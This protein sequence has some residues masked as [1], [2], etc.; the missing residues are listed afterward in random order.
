MVVS[1]TIAKASWRFEEQ[2]ERQQELHGGF[3]NNRNNSKGFMV[4][5][6]TAIG[7][8]RFE[9]QQE[10]HGGLN[11]SKRFMEVEIHGCLNHRKRFMEV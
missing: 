10:V 1:G 4:V 6:G 9:Q 11:N 5:S 3:G 8:W 2:Q 7:S